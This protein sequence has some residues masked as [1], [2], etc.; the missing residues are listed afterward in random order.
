MLTKA[1]ELKDLVSIDRDKSGN[2][3]TITVD[4]QEELEKEELSGKFDK[5]ETV[6]QEKTGKLIV[7][8]EV[9][10]DPPQAWDSEEESGLFKLIQSWVV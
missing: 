4:L 7:M 2:R 1:I 10:S 5:C 6:F 3:A 9:A 8:C